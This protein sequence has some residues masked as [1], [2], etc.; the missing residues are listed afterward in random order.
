MKQIRGIKRDLIDWT[1]KDNEE[2]MIFYVTE[3]CGR[4]ADNGWLLGRRE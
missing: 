3:F 2:W 1:K 4:K